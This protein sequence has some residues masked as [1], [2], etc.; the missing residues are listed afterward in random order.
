MNK[1]MHR[2]I[3]SALCF[4][5]LLTGL[6]RRALAA[7]DVEAGG[8][9]RKLEKTQTGE[10]RKLDKV[11][12][13]IAW[14]LADLESNGLLKQGDA[15]NVATFQVAI[16]KVAAKRMPTAAAHLRNARFD[17]A[18]SRRHT[19]SADVEVDAILS[20][21][22]EVLAGSS[23]LLASEQLVRELKDLIKIQTLVRNRTVEWGKGILI[24]PDI[25]GA[26]KGPLIQDQTK[27]ITRCQTFLEKLQQ[28]GKDAMDDAS[29]SRFQQAYNVLSPPK[30]TSEIISKITTPEPSTG[31][32]LRAAVEQIER[33]EVLA[34]VGAQ[35]RAIAS[36]KSALQILSAGQFELAEFVAGLEKLIEK[37]K[38][39]RKDTAAEEDLAGKSAFYEARQIEIQDEATNYSF[40]APD[41]FVSKKGEYL[42]EPLMTALQEAVDA[43]K[44][45]KKD[46][47]L[48][49]LKAARKKDA[50]VALKAAQKN[51]ALTAQDKIIALLQSV[52]GTAKA[53]KEEKEE[54]DD[55]FW[56]ES[57]VVPED[58]W[59]LPP[60]G[61]EEDAA[62]KD[63]DMPEI[64]EGITSTAL[65]V[66]PEGTTVGSAPDVSS[67]AAA[68]KVIGLEEGEEDSE[69]GDFI[70]DEGPPSA[71]SDAAPEAPGANTEGNTDEVAKDRLARESM[72]RQRQK[73]KIQDYVRQLPP[74]FRRQVADYY[75]VIA[76]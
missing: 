37:Q 35:D 57:P 75:Q 2:F 23:T 53:L 71:G 59:M 29:K 15:E 44:A 28:A 12:G 55:P 64:F 8:R 60:D 43:L 61:E 19:T 68:N 74:E 1:K 6:P 11:V 25:A 39:L 21:L 26:G 46:E 22:A 52:Y 5:V 42:V 51:K 17:Q 36:F 13:E 31:E 18:E 4:T 45:A 66:Q 3:L 50:I 40:E 7:N 33:L 76:E 34:A 58:L 47:A 14:L 16:D 38:A 54:G 27:I 20:E 67:A 49:A 41:L 32:V 48:A 72:Q 65:M 30:P 10:S 9:L 62:M 63:E 73:V 70:T 56:A 24:S 69:P